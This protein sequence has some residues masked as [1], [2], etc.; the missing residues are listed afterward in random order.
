MDDPVA[1]P[2]QANFDSPQRAPSALKSGSAAV[3]AAALR[4]AAAD[5]LPVEDVGE[6]TLEHPLAL[7]DAQA[8]SRARA[9]TPGGESA[10]LGLSTSA[11]VRFSEFGGSVGSDDSGEYSDGSQPS[12]NLGMFPGITEDHIKQAFDEIDYDEN[13]FVGASE[14]RYLLMLQGVKPTDEEI[15]EM[16]RM[17][18]CSGDGQVD[19]SEF[20]MLFAPD[21][22]V[23]GEMEAILATSDSPEKKERDMRLA[24]LKKKEEA[25]PTTRDVDRALQGASAFLGVAKK[26][27][28]DEER[29]Q[30]LPEVN[31]IKPGAVRARPG[32]P[33]PPLA[34]SPTQSRLMRMAQKDKTKPDPKTKGKGKWGKQ[35]Q[36]EWKDK[37][38]DEL[39]K[40]RGE[41]GKGQDEKG[42]GDWKGK[43]KGQ[44][45]RHSGM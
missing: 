15:D 17:L 41:E 43:G 37:Q 23:P 2:G 28:R 29:Q 24:E 40:L 39:N 6:T 7:H 25:G 18:D 36:A 3:Q 26:K 4:A 12:L 16:L 20:L 10:T 22:L 44:G 45:M 8:L 31:Q 9:R 32:F 19:Y 42:N 35:W 21:S 33:L 13:G 5:R 11:S 34:L 30:H 1:L 27:Q 14:L 38:R